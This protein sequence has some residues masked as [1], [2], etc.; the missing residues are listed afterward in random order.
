MFLCGTH[1]VS[2]IKQNVLLKICLFDLR[3]GKQQQQK[4]PQK[5]YVDQIIFNPEK[6]NFGGAKTNFRKF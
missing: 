4:K 2:F 3:E 1:L 6:C 5:S